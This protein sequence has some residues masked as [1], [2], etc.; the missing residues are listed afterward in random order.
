VKAGHRPDPSNPGHR[1]DPGPSRPRRQ[2]DATSLQGLAHPLRV[3]LLDHLG[4]HGPATATQLAAT[5]GESSGATSYHLRQLERYGFVEEDPARGSGRERWWRRVPGGISIVGHELAQS[6]ATRDATNLVLNEW[7]RAKAARIER[8]RTTYQL[9]PVEWQDASNESSAHLR[10]SAGELAELN[11]LIDELVTPWADRT[12]DREGDE[13]VDIE[14]QT[15]SF[16][17][18]DPPPGSPAEASQ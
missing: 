10:L 17:V 14:L 9:W 7:N 3:Q 12:R 8:W 11:R 18:G 15:Y 5:L 13:Y 6:P 4:L 2:V 1:P 16:P